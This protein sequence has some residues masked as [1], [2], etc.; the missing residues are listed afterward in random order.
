MGKLVGLAGQGGE[1]P[2]GKG[3]GIILLNKIDETRASQGLDGVMRD[4]GGPPGRGDK[5]V[6][7]ADLQADGAIMR[8][9]YFHVIEE[10]FQTCEFLELLAPEIRLP[11]A[12]IH[13]Q[14]PNFLP[15]SGEAKGEVELGD[16]A[17]EKVI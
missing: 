5:D 6:F 3:E 11:V 4:V 16:V 7:P 14:H 8:A 12:S 9:H 15:L 17:A 2:H 13:E 10:I 1:S